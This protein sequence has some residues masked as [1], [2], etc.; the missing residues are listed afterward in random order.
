MFSC[1]AGGDSSS[2][3]TMRLF[4]E[5][6]RSNSSTSATL[7]ALQGS[8]D[9]NRD[10][11]MHPG[12]EIMAETQSL[13]AYLMKYINDWMYFETTWLEE[14]MSPLQLTS[15]LLCQEF[16]SLGLRCRESSGTSFV[17]GGDTV[18]LY[19]IRAL[20]TASHSMWMKPQPPAG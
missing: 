9:C 1:L 13:P 19:T 2:E 11:V 20:L 12:D 18:G 15:L 4:I 6:L 5:N 16:Y 8:R 7:S 17:F 3:S 10:D 14:H